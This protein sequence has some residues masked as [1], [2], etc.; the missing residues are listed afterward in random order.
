MSDESN[1]L[2][3]LAEPNRTEPGTET[4][5]IKQAAQSLGIGE[6]AV[7]KR[8]DEGKLRAYREGR[9]WRLYLPL[10][11]TSEPNRTARRTEPNESTERTEPPDLKNQ[12]HPLEDVVRRQD[13]EIAFLRSRLEAADV[14][15]SELRRLMLMAE[16]RAY[17]LQ[18]QVKLLAAP[19]VEEPVQDAQEAS[20]VAPDDTPDATAREHREMVDFL[21]QRLREYRQKID[22]QNAQETRTEQETSETVNQPLAVETSAQRPPARRWWQVWRR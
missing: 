4:W 20:A 22:A 21:T 9:E 11:A 7:L 8:I 16:Q 6:R 10:A 2:P 12:P 18:E 1:E 3:P 17:G 13:E 14:E 5:S 15:K 19:P